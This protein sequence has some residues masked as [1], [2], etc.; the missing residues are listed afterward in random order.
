MR[1]S[2]RIEIYSIAMYCAMSFSTAALGGT[3]AWMRAQLTAQVPSHD[4]KAD[5]ATMYSETVLTV[6]PNGKIKRLNRQVIKILRPDGVV[7]A[8]PRF[9]YGPMYPI[10]DLHG[11]SIPPDG[12]DYEV[13]ERDAIDSA[14]IDVDGGEL[15]TDLRMKLLAIPG[16]Q[17]ERSLAMRSSRNC[18]PE[19][20]SEDWEVQDIVPIGE[21][22][23]TLILPAGWSY[24]A[25]WLNH[26]VEPPLIPVQINGSGS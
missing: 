12:K 13:K 18:W 15:V 4:A 9:Y 7:Q 23:F 3:P 5:A 11:W 26:N 21:E 8:R 25:R 22:R 20:L 16:A 1:C 10:T 6:T 24:E 14:D 19:F 2:A 17:V